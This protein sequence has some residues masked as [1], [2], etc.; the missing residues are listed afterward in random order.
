MHTVHC[1]S[2]YSFF[3]YHNAFTYTNLQI[4]QI[5]KNKKLTFNK[6]T[7]EVFSVKLAS[8]AQTSTSV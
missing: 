7:Q 3:Y 6:S 4:L 5:F 8:R 1:M 2:I